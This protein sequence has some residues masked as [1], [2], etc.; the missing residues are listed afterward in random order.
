MKLTKTSVVF[1]QTI[2]PNEKIKIEK[3]FGALMQS[4]YLERHVFKKAEKIGVVGWQRTDDADDSQFLSI[5]NYDNGYGFMGDVGRANI[6]NNNE[7][8]FND[9]NNLAKISAF[10]KD[11]LILEGATIN[12]VGVNLHGFC[13]VKNPYENLN[14]LLNKDAEAVKVGNFFP[15]SI[16]LGYNLDIQDGKPNDVAKI[17]LEK[18]DSKLVFMANFNHDMNSVSNA[19]ECKVFLDKFLE[20]QMFL[21]EILTKVI[22]QQ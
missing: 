6:E 15:A 18:K 16:T 20:F 3:S 5:N 1:A 8:K 13:D 17:V 19:S 14:K 22:E 7:L 21:K 11:Y 9:T 2:I 4:K 10:L 12:A